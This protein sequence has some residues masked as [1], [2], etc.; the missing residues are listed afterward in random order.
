[1]TSPLHSLSNRRVLLGIC[2]GIAAYK[3]AELIRLL[4]SKG[5]ECRVV[6]TAAASEFITPMTLQ[7]LSGHPVHQQLF[8]PAQEQSMGH[9]TL[10]RWADLILVAPATANTVAKLSHGIA[11]DLLTTTLLA[12]NCPKMIAPAMNQQMWLSP[13]SQENLARLVR[14][15]YQ[16]LGPE[17]GELA[18]G[19]HGV[20][21]ML[22]PEKLLEA[23]ESH[24]IAGPLHGRRVTITAGPTREAI[25]PVRYIT[26][27]SSGK[28]GFAIAAAAQRLGARVR[29]V[30]GPVTLTSPPGV[31]RI[32]VESASEMLEV[33]LQDPGEI[34]I[35]CAAVAD[36]RCQHIAATKIKKGGEEMQLSLLRNPDI[37]HQVAQLALPPFTVGFAAET[38][39]LERYAR[40]KLTRKGIDMIAAN[41]VGRPDEGFEVDDNRLQLFWQGGGR[42]LPRA[43]KVALAVELMEVVMERSGLNSVNHSM[44]S[45]ST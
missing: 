1:M 20:G 33:V 9:I 25:D 39:E 44:E 3:A 14:Y 15:G 5:A 13:P 21:R 37:L 30:A 28:M 42:L 2:G 41:W 36:Y 11:D 18:C 38:D 24:F 31:A 12:S 40:D 7:A 34:F 26:N 23:V 19:E 17:T 35:A 45:S 29:L 32:D 16:I 43:S 10:A 6:M 22:A 4:R 8:D 27:R